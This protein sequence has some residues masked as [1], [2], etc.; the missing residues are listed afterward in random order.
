MGQRASTLAIA[1]AA[2]FA[3]SIAG[4][5]TLAG[6]PSFTEAGQFGQTQLARGIATG[7]DGTVYVADTNNNRIQAFTA[8]GGSKGAFGGT[9][10]ASGKFQGPSDVDVAPD[11]NVWVADY[12]NYRLQELRPDGSFVRSIVQGQF[13]SPGVGIDKDGNVYA[14]RLGGNGASTVQ[15]Y[16]KA[17]NFAPTTSWGGMSYARDLEVSPD[18]S[19][20]IANEGTGRAVLRFDLTGKSLGS[21]PAGSANPLGIGIDLDCNV[22]VGDIGARRIVKYSPSGKLLGEVKPKTETIANDVAF[23]PNGDMY[24]SN[25]GSK[26]MRLTEDRKPGAAAVPG[27]IAAKLDGKAYVAKVAYAPT[28]IACPD[29][30][31]A[32]ATIAGKGIAG[33]ASGLQLP[34][35]KATAIDITLKGKA[36][37]TM[38]GRTVPATF[39]IVLQT[40]GRTTTETK[41]VVISIPKKK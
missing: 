28:G 37:T 13:L 8:T 10:T 35:G 34:I 4:A 21:I 14:V 9:G 18:G 33:K 25:G 3:V 27:R 39:T 30:L 38:Q 26:V 15:K 20:Y 29:T 1:A 11:G 19:V 24:V 41:K 5:S 6:K 7:I 36:L 2:L 31:G 17:S 16:D 32:T 22:W 12:I 40:N 23:G